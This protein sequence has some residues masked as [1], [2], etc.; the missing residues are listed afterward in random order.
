MT[1]ATKLPKVTAA[2]DLV[3]RIRSGLQLPPELLSAP[4]AVRFQVLDEAGA[5]V[6]VAHVEGHKV[7]YDRV[8]KP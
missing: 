3:P 5:L 2:A 1:E 7:V 8:F 4:E 6:A